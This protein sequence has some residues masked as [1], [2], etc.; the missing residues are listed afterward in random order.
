MGGLSATGRD[1]AFAPESV[2]EALPCGVIVVDPDGRALGTNQ[3]ARE[4]LPDL[5]ENGTGRCHELL[6]CNRPGGPCTLGCLAARAAGAA[7]PLPEFRVDVRGNGPASAVWVIAAPLLHQPGAVL[8][9]RP[10]DAKDRRRRSD[11]HWLAGPSLRIHV[12]GRTR[13]QS[14]EDELGG[15]WL[16]QRPG[17]LLKLLV[18]ERGRMVPA[19]KIAE[20]IW[21]GG[22]PQAVSNTR[23]FVHRLRDRLEPGRSGHGQSSFIV[24]VAGGYT[25]DRER[26]WIDAD[27]FEQ[28][29][30]DGLKA[31]QRVDTDEARARLERALELYGGDLLADEPYADWAYG[32]RDRLRGLAIRALHTLLVMA[33]ERDDIEAATMHLTRLTELEPFDSA[34][35]RELLGALLAQ[36]RR[37]DAHRRYA[38]FAARIRR[39]FGE[40]LDFDLKSLAP[41]AA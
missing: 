11:P 32:E 23:H 14:A 2:L 27:E 26:V 21:P 5:P 8:H 15:E 1:E 18:C 22:G 30:K 7:G 13:V 35:H 38:G 24:G 16:H 25:I 20:S 9:L 40:E 10:G 37:S 36:G 17:E 33:R 12:L 28:E 34:I 29:V 41:P 4:L 39:E 19:D 31:L 3:M 6:A